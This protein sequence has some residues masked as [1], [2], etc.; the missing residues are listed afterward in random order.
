L[1]FFGPNGR[2]RS[3]PDLACGVFL[4]HEDIGGY[5]G[6]F[7][8]WTASPFCWW[9]PYLSRPNPDAAFET[10]RKQLVVA[11]SVLAVCLH[12]H[13]SHC[14]V[15][16]VPNMSSTK[17]VNGFWDMH[18]NAHHHDVLSRTIKGVRGTHHQTN[19][20]YFRVQCIDSGWIACR[21]YL[22]VM[23]PLLKLYETTEPRFQPMISRLPRTS[24][25]ALVGSS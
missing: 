3:R 1:N 21:G 11:L 12:R 25:V 15:V 5:M 7:T 17:S 4:T 2:N 20:F 6:Q 14:C 9:V 23:R 19:Y 16:L 8:F 22:H 13:D 10:A 24:N 18:N